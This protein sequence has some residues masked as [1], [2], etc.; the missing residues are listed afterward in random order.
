MRKSLLLIAALVPMSGLAGVLSLSS[1]AGAAS[2]AADPTTAT[3][4]V[5]TACGTGSAAADP[6]NLDLIPSKPVTGHQS[7]QGV[8][9]DDGCGGDDEHGGSEHEGAEGADD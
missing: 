8:G 6:I 1:S 4:T 5:A 7:I 3:E 2:I 9:D